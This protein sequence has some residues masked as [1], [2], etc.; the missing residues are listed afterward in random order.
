MYLNKKGKKKRKLV[1]RDETCEVPPPKKRGRAIRLSMEAVRVIIYV[2]GKGV[3]LLRRSKKAEHFPGK[4]E[5]PG[6]KAEKDDPN[7]DY[8]AVLEVKEETGLDI[9]LEPGSILRWEK[10]PGQFLAFRDAHYSCT[11][12]RGYPQRP[13]QCDHI[14]AHIKSRSP[15]EHDEVVW[16]EPIGEELMALGPDLMEETRKA[17]MKFRLNY[18]PV[19]YRPVS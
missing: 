6:G 13:H 10:P 9:D 1:N 2:P 14:A 5:L 16:I 3:L 15:R 11:V 4:L 7:L 12:V 17:L 18:L 19:D 8:A